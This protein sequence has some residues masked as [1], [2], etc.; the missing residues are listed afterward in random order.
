MKFEIHRHGF[1]MEPAVQ[2]HI[3][4]RL[5]LVLGRFG[6]RIGRVTVHL[7]DINGPRG[8]LDKRCRI[9]ARLRG[10]GRVIVEDTNAELTA[11]VHGASDRLGQSV[12]RQ[13]ERRRD[14]RLLGSRWRP[15][16]AMTAPVGVPLDR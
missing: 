8:G 1:A 15:P 12:R 9:I 5:R 6:P 2:D 11:A 16:H 14:R 3:E 4:R 7:A 13:L 10:G